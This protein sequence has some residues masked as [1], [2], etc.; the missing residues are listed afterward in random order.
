VHLGAGRLP[1]KR[2]L[3]AIE[4]PDDLAVSAEVLG[5]DKLVGWDAEPAG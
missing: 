4:V 2:Y 1:L 3:V 5:P